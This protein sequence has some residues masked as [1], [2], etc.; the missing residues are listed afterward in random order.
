MP[1]ISGLKK[2]SF[3]AITLNNED[4]QTTINSLTQRIVILEAEAGITT[5]PP[6]TAAPTTTSSGTTQPSGTTEPPTTSSGTTQP[7]STTQPPT[8]SPP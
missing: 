7:P 4:L 5:A 1:S 3:D 8:T 2:G 6:T